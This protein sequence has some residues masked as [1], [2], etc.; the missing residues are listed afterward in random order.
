[1]WDADVKFVV[2]VFWE[3]PPVAS[4]VLT[5]VTM[6]GQGLVVLLQRV[7]GGVPQPSS[8]SIRC[9]S[10]HR[11]PRHLVNWCVYEPEL[12][13]VGKQLWMDTVCRYCP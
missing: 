9:T 3:I 1:M 6:A 2:V 4:R 7:E 5:A 8:R 11:C 12:F 13:E 10:R